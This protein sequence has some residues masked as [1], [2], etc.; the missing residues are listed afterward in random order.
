MKNLMI[1]AHEMTR[2]IKAQY[3]EVNYQVQLGLCMSYLLEE[4]VEIL[5][6]VKDWM[7]NKIG[8]EK[9]I[10]RFVSGEIFAVIKET[11]KAYQVIL[12]ASGLRAVSTWVPK[13][14]VVETE[15]NSKTL[16]GLTYDEAIIEHKLEM[17]FFK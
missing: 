10:K 13:S 1:R 14:Q 16:F 3:P 2:E 8:Q 6:E 15:G 9:G 12:T 11:E 7:L 5:L 17:S 4:K